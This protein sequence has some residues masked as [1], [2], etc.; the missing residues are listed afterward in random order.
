MGFELDF[1]RPGLIGRQAA[2]RILECNSLTE[3]YGLTLSEQQALALAE[4]RS[5]ALKET[6]RVEFGGGV[7]E[8]IIRAFCDSP[9]LIT[10]NYEETLQELIRLFYFYKNETLDRI[11]DDDLIRYMKTAFDGICGGSL[12]LLGG[13]ELYNLARRIRLGYDP[14]REESELSGE[15]DGDGTD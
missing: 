14:E 15:E 4:G 7:I 2:R 10:Q 1:F 6:G 9:F 3:R 12:E 8:K 13:R 5:A 11:G